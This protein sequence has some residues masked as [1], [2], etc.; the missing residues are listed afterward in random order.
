MGNLENISTVPPAVGKEGHAVPMKIKDAIEIYSKFGISLSEFYQEVYDDLIQHKRQI[1]LDNS[2]YLHALQL[3]SL[4]ARETKHSFRMLGGGCV[5]GF[6][7][8]MGET[9]D[10]MLSRIKSNRGFVQIITIDPV[11]ETPTLRY[12]ADKYKGVMKVYYATAK[13]PSSVVHYITSDD[14]TVRVEK[15]HG[16]LNDD[17]PVDTI[18]AKVHFNDQSKSKWYSADF[19]KLAKQ[20][21]VTF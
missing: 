15:A 18:A 5:D 1:T 2:N 8:L 21:H 12:L 17:S 10:V 16:P 9:F 7:K 6:V 11:D 13:D 14:N 19:D 3:T 20:L 4:M